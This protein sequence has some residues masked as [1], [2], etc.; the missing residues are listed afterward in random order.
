VALEWRP[1]WIECTEHDLRCALFFVE[2]KSKREKKAKQE[3]KLVKVGLLM[4]IPSQWAS[5]DRRTDRAIWKKRKSYLAWQMGIFPVP[6][7]IMLAYWRLTMGMSVRAPVC[8]ARNRL[9]ISMPVSEFKPCHQKS[10]S[11]SVMVNP[12]RYMHS[13]E[14]VSLRGSRPR[15]PAARV[16]ICTSR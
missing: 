11:L 3:G 9:A 16:Q 2:R 10:T 8:D 6:R 1:E 13:M 7:R 14:L 4:P 12:R 15:K 5:N